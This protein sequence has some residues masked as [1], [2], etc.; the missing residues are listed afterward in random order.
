MRLANALLRERGVML[1]QWSRTLGRARRRAT[2]GHEVADA[3]VEPAEGQ[4]D[5]RQAEDPPF[6]RLLVAMMTAITP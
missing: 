6:H 2:I 3:L 4:L 5:L 1:L